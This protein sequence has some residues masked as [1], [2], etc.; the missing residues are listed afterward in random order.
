[1]MNIGFNVPHD[2]Y[3]VPAPYYEQFPPEEIELWDNVNQVHDRFKENW[4][5]KVVTEMR[6]PDGEEIGMREYMRIY[7]G[8]V[9]F[10][11]DQI[12]RVLQ[13]LE[14]SGEMENTIIVFLADHGDMAGGHGM[15]WKSTEAFYEE[16]AAIPLIV[17]YPKALKPQVNKTPASTLDVFPTIFDMLGRD[18]L[19]QTEGKSLVPFMTG[20]KNPSDADP[21]TFSER[22]S[23]NPNAQRAVLPEMAGHFMVRGKGFKYMIYSQNEEPLYREEPVEILFHLDSDPGETIDLANN[24]EFASV[25]EEM[26]RALHD[27]LER[28][29]GWK[30]VPVLKH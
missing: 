26:N 1:M 28:T 8:N 16:V 3:L 2:P 27:W 5:R 30:G 14:E 18:L 10:L 21:Y 13:A 19:K 25:K 17:R 24:P 22:I 15:T 29:G 9:K 23:R 7:Y 6:G 12:G 4:S 20:K 11:D